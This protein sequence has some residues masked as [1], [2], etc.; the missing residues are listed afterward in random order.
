MDESTT[1]LLVEVPYLAHPDG[2]GQSATFL[3]YLINEISIE[4]GFTWRLL[5][6]NITNNRL[7]IPHELD[8]LAPIWVSPKHIPKADVLLRYSV[9]TEDRRGANRLISYTMFETDD[10]PPHF[11][12]AFNVSDLVLT[13]TEWGKRVFEQSTNTPV[14][15]C[16]VAMNPGFMKFLGEHKCIGSLPNVFTLILNGTYH[17]NYDRKRHTELF[18]EFK[19]RH[20]EK[21]DIRL[22]F[23]ARG[24]DRR[25]LK[26]VQRSK[27][28]NIHSVSNPL[29]WPELLKLYLKSHVGVF[30]SKGEGWGM[31]QVELALL[32]RPIV[33][34]NN[35]A[36]TYVG[37][38]MPW[39]IPVECN[40]T[41]EACY[42]IH[43]LYNTGDWYLC[44][45]EDFM[46][47]VDMV[48]EEWRSDI[49]AFNQKIYEAHSSNL[50]RDFVSHDVVKEQLR[51]AIKSQLG[52]GL[53]N[54]EPKN[55]PSRNY[56]RR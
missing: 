41:E 3:V 43:S 30:P 26:G 9:P 6:T 5:E 46:D 10:T 49:S 42:R 12:N 48:Y 34:A 21:R 7:L 15:V 25:L 13:P 27:R 16:H 19:K 45:M 40:E 50:M 2:Y 38:H 53:V 31:P 18:H 8:Y 29:V 17:V 11:S 47:K 20:W 51:E 24:M 39:G 4:E 22:I 14:A 54:N 1:D 32:G 23:K 35:S 28:A 52:R 44:D 55:I 36:L 56:K 37:P 33:Y